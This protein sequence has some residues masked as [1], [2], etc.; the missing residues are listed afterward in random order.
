M[1]LP[2]PAIAPALPYPSLSQSSVPAQRFLLGSSSEKSE[3]ALDVGGA[4]WVGEP[5]N[6]LIPALPC[7]AHAAGLL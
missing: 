6:S 4:G 3:V 2:Q 5:E 1:A 7:S